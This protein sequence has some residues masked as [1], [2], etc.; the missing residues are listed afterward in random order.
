MRP[1]GVVVIA[2]L[3]Q[4]WVGENYAGLTVTLWIHLTSIHILLADEVIK[5]V[6]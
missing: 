1:S 4:L 3:Q 5:T 2:G 6:P